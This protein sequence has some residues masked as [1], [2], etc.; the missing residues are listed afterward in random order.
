MHY[1]FACLGLFRS[2]RALST[3][4]VCPEQLALL[5]DRKS[6]VQ[7]LNLAARI[8]LLEISTQIV[9]T[10]QPSLCRHIAALCHRC[11]ALSQASYLLV[12][13][14]YQSCSLAI[15]M[16]HHLDWKRY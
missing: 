1:K 6:L 8:P 4:V 13:H 11:Y 9:W 15:A 3:P 16:I 7:D 14:Y 2:Y 12:A 5:A 10:Y